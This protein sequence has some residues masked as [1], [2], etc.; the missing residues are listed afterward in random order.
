MVGIEEIMVIYYYNIVHIYTNVW[1]YIVSSMTMV[2][3]KE[4][5]DTTI[6]DPYHP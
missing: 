1:L 4:G 6:I 3:A 2:E 5:S